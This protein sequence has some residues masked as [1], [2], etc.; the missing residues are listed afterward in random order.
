MRGI[1]RNLDYLGRIT[2]PKE[3]RKKLGYEYKQEIDLYIVGNVMHLERGIGRSLDDLG[4][5]TIPIEVRRRLGLEVGEPVDVWVEDDGIC[6]KK[7]CLQCV[8]C[9]SEDEKQLMNIDGVLICRDCG[10]KVVDKFME[11]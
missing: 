3:Y 7:A 1:I 8:I 10:V 9:G 6:I 11:D 2:I 5:Y 4:R